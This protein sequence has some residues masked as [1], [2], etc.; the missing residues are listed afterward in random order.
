MALQH[1]YQGIHGWFDFDDIYREAVGEAR[2]GARFVEVGTWC[3]RSAAYMAVE[4]VN[5]GKKIE[6]YCVDTWKGSPAPQYQEVVYR[7][8][9]IYD[10]FLRSMKDGGVQEVVRP[11]VSDSA[12]AASLFEDRSLDFVF[13]DASHDFDGVRRD[14]AA[15]LPKVRVGGIF[16]GHDAG[17]P[18]LLNA[19]TAYVP[20]ARVSIRG[21]SWFHRVESVDDSPL[22]RAVGVADSSMGAFAVYDLWHRAQLLGIVMPSPS[23]PAGDDAE[24]RRKWGGPPGS[25]VFA[26]PYNITTRDW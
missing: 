20:R 10:A 24:Y 5:S 11:I 4:I 2:D 23:L 13:I 1:F 15:W 17:C 19:V 14:V 25:E 6:F 21:A 18:G 9:S 3:G 12:D 22:A 7:Y 8:G 16:A 26:V